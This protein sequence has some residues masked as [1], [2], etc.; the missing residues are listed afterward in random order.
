MR[1]V[2]DRNRA[3]WDAYSDKYTAR[4][5]AAPE[6][7]KL[8][9]DPAS[10]FHKT[11]WAMIREALPDFRAKRVL[12]PSSGDNKAAFAFAMLGA[13]VTSA[14]ISQRQLENAEKAAATLGIGGMRFVR[15]DTMTLE[16]IE[17]GAYD[18][19]YTS[20]GVHVWI[21]DLGGM[22][23]NIAR[24][25]KPGGKYALFEIHPFN[26]PFDDDARIVKP[27]EATGPFERDGEVTFAWRLMDILGATL[28]A[29]LRLLRFEE[30]AAEK[31]YTDPAWVPC[32][33]QVRDGYTEYDHAE[34]DALYD[35]RTNPM[36]ALPQLFSAVWEK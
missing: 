29:G 12:V 5:H 25:M 9:R 33:K 11:T 34:V 26:R 23:R 21:D 19:V 1:N 13:E 3:S 27:Y 10:A 30:M 17:D 14:D 24:V 35:W 36:A 8:A 16:G 20:N 15:A 31:S 28:G 32:E 4:A 18:F 7:Q 6:L 22:Y 2:A